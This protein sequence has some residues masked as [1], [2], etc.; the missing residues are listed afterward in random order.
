MANNPP[1]SSY[2]IEVHDLAKLGMDLSFFPD[3]DHIVYP[4]GSEDG[5]VAGSAIKVTEERAPAEVG[6]VE[7]ARKKV[8]VDE[9]QPEV[10]L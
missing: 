2:L 9:V 10:E 4:L 3:Q 1:D 5:E 6:Q 8:G 7:V